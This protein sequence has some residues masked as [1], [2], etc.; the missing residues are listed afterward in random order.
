[1]R[2]LGLCIGASSVS[3]VCLERDDG[4]AGVTAS[5]S[6]I[7]DGN[8]EKVIRG[9]L[10]ET[11]FAE[12]ERIAVTGRKFRS[13]VETATIPEPEAVEHAYRYVRDGAAGQ[14]NASIIVSA[15]GETVMV[16]QINGINVQTLFLVLSSTLMAAKPRIFIPR[17]N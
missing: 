8:P 12:I 13:M 3:Y 4:Y 14:S 11:R 2:S 6:I 17:S 5:N 7:H 10:D 9:L 15:G 16:Y 1:M